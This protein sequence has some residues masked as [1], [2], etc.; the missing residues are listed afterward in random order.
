VVRAL[1]A[2]WKIVTTVR[3]LV[4][5]TTAPPTSQTKT[6]SAT[7]LVGTLMKQGHVSSATRPS[8]LTMLSVRTAPLTA[9]HVQV[10]LDSAHLV[11][12]QPI[13][14]HM[15]LALAHLTTSSLTTRQAI[16]PNLFTV[17]K[18]NTTMVG[19][20]AEIVLITVP[21]VTP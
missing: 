1:V 8:S 7:V 19:M 20:V 4:P 16:A 17:A 5:A 15:V 12:T 2:V 9:R 3:Y 10:Q 6:E 11:L 13:L 18:V 21:R 14:S